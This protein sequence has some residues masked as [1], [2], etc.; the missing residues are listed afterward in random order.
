M[1]LWEYKTRN[2]GLLAELQEKLPA[3]YGEEAR[4]VVEKLFDKTRRLRSFTLADYFK[5]VLLL[6]K[7][8]PELRALIPEPE[9]VDELIG[10]QED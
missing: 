6:S 8:Y 3:K 7:K 5:T 9:E 10:D 2:L 1:K 4:E